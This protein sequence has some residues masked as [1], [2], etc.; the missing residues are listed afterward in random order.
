MSKSMEPCRVYSFWVLLNASSCC[1][2]Y[3]AYAFHQFTAAWK[4]RE[5]ETERGK[6]QIQ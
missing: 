3:A 4:E 6:G 1:Y 2:C 5:K